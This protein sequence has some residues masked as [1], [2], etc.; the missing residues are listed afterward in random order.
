MHSEGENHNETAGETISRKP[1][2]R[3]AAIWRRVSEDEDM[4][5]ASA[6]PKGRAVH[7]RLTAGFW[8]KI[9]HGKKRMGGQ[10]PQRGGGGV[11]WSGPHTTGEV[12][13]EECVA[14][15]EVRTRGCRGDEVSEKLVHGFGRFILQIG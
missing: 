3:G 12:G 13:E 15:E 9:T 10:C 5:K 11:G 1:N 7:D 14:D 2:D 6:I 8:E 4:G